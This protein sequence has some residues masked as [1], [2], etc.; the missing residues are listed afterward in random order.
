MKGFNFKR[1][2]NVLSEGTTPSVD[3]TAPV[4]TAFV[5]P[6]TS[7]SLT[8]PITT[9]TATDNVAVT[10]YK[11]TE[12]AT[13]PLAGALGWTT[14]APTTYTFTTDGNK[15]L[16]AWAKDA[17]GNV[18]TSASA[19]VVITLP[20]ATKPVV[21]TFTIPAT[22]SS[23]VVPVSSFTAS[24]NKAVTGFK[25]TESATAPNAGD[26][27][28]NTDTPTSYTFASE[29]SKTLYAW[30]KDAAGNISDSLNDSV[31]VAVAESVIPPFPTD[32][33]NGGYTSSQIDA[34]LINHAFVL[35]TTGVLFVLQGN[36]PRTSDSDAAYAHLEL[37]NGFYED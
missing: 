32:I 12:S 1:G 11:I 29:G 15:T 8:I 2:F 16:Y 17:A 22:S 35:D 19:Q 25:I 27:G 24:D 7:D 31:V 13:P 37:T 9:F 33:E 21:T 18:S 26:A 5:I 14:T 6:S 30:A 28:W 36:E 3:D 10:K 34:W 23:L 4:V 20:D